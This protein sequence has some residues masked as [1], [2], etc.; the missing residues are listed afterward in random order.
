LEG[1]RAAAMAAR[2]KRWKD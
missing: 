1:E 2:C